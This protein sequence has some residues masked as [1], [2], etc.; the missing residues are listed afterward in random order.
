[1]LDSVSLSETPNS[2]SGADPSASILPSQEKSLS[3]IFE[4]A[5]TL[6]GLSRLEAKLASVI[7]RLPSLVQMRRGIVC[8]FEHDGLPEIIVDDGRSE[9]R[10]ARCGG[11]LAARSN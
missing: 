8:L 4:I 7:E 3:T 9:G 11:A 1:M 5:H 6:T 10:D 2:T